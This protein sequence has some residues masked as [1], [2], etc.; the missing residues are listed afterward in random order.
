MTENKD[1]E[2]HQVR[3]SEL[4]YEALSLSSFHPW[5]CKLSTVQY[6]IEINF[7]RWLRWSGISGLWVPKT[8]QQYHIRQPLAFVVNAPTTI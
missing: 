2:R 5:Y 6:S 8:V 1:T 7:R 3:I 4:I